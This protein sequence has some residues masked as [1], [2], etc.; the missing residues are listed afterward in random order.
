MSRSYEVNFDGLPGPTH[1]FGGLAYGN[2]ASMHSKSEESHPKQ[3]ALQ[4]L[5]K[6]RLLGDLGLVQGILPPHERPYFPLLRDLGFR[7]SDIEIAQTASAQFP[8]LFAS[9]CASSFMWTANAATVTPSTD[10][11]DEHVHFTPANLIAQFH[12]SFEAETTQRVLKM[13]FADP[14]YFNHHD[15]L[16]PSSAFADEGAANHTR[17]C[18][19]HD[20]PGVHFFVYGRREFTPAKYKPQ[21]FPARHTY[22]ASVAIANRHRLYKNHDFYAQQNPEAID[23]GVFHNDVVAVGHRHLFL[24]HESAYIG[25]KTIIEELKRAVAEICEVDLITIPVSERDV[26]LADA[27][28]TYLFNS[29]IVDAQDNMMQ[30]IAPVECQENE[31]VRIF[32]DKVQR[33]PDNPIRAIHYVD[34]RE[35]MKNGGGPACLR[36]RIPLKENEIRSITPNVLLTEKLYDR[37]VAWVEKHYRDRLTLKELNDPH[38]IHESQTA[39]DELTGILKLGSIYS[40][41]K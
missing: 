30:I 7:G 22:E 8:K 16:H 17:F 29:Q 1:N 14:L 38:L 2:L 19:E 9:C 25:A 40:F 32:F 31:T 18:K 41:Q 27:V 23:A 11:A 6:M 4:S 3:A 35:S 15:P 28:S 26:P 34:L 13:I 5:Q 24:Y 21:K 10:A 12:R 37:L 33:N 39:L 36:L 20:L